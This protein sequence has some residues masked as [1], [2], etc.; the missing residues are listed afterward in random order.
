MTC[1]GSGQADSNARQGAGNAWPPAVWS[2]DM[3]CDAMDTYKS[4]LPSKVVEVDTHTERVKIHYIGALTFVLGYWGNTM[5]DAVRNTKGGKG[6]AGS[7]TVQN[8]H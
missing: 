2:V 6:A 7:Y 3:R 5:R 8:C 4:W 1:C